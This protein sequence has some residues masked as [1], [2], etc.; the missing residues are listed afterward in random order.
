MMRN[1]IADQLKYHT[2][3][4]HFVTRLPARFQWTIHNVVAHPLSELLYQLG[5]EDWGNRIHDETAPYHESGTGR[6]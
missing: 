2:P 5:F 3:M 6:G 1:F 4:R